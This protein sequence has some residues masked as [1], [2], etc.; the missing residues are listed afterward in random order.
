MKKGVHAG[1]LVG[2]VAKMVGGG[3]GGKPT[4]AQAGGREPAKLQ[5]ALEA[6]RRQITGMLAGSP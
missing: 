3:G 2:E 1:K 4:M 5:G 6:G